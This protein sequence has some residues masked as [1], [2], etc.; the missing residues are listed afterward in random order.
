MSTNPPTPWLGISL[1]DYEQHMALP[2]VGQAQLIRDVF[3]A[4]LGRHAPQS[5]AVLGCAGGNGFDCV[6]PSVRRVVGVDI[7]PDF[8]AAARQRFGSKPGLE[9]Y[10]ADILHDDLPFDAVDFIFAALLFEYVEL[11]TALA[12]IRAKLARGGQLVVVLQLASS[13]PE[14]TPS[15]YGG[16]AAL[17]TTM[18]LVPPQE[19]IDLAAT[20]GLAVRGDA[21]VESTGHKHFSVLTFEAT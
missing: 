4:A 2:Y 9:L 6:P 17:S 18:R 1:A 21:T 11:A 20:V 13:V 5:V 7:N 14:V 8:I 19:L 3:A 15:P 10:V 12:K 16:L